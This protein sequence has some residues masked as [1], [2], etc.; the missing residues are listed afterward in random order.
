MNFGLTVDNF[1]E[2]QLKILKLLFERDYLQKE[3]QKNLKT[4]GSNLHYHLS[5]LEKYNLIRK[6]TLQQIGNAKINRISINPSA[7][8]Y[9]RQ[10]LGFKIEDYTLITGFGTLKTGYQI[11]DKVFKILKENY[12]PISRVVCFTS[13]DAI[14][15]RKEH[16]KHKELMKID[17]YIQYPYEEY[18]DIK[19]KFFKE[20][21]NI[22]SEEMKTSDIIID[23]TPLS[24]L[25]SFK[26]LELANKYNL[27]CIYL[28]INKDGDSELLSMSKM[29]IEGIIQ[30]FN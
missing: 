2:N 17:R 23:L 14:E 6:E 29:K 19:S 20:I 13:P 30:K 4:T 27:P 21:E 11:P 3:L 10:I 1:S 9:I 15:K 12:Y 26:L 28:G 24:K 22:I 16:Q 7:R 18:R 25:F 8:Q 5:R